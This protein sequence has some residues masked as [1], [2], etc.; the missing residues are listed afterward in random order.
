MSQPPSIRDY[1]AQVA[2]TLNQAGAQASRLSIPPGSPDR[3]RVAWALLRLAFD[4]AASISSLFYHHGEELAGSPFALLRPMNEALRRGAWI[5]L[6]ASDEAVQAFIDDDDLPPGKTMV[7]DLEHIEPFD[8][9][10]IFSQQFA[11]AWTKFH[12]FTHAGNQ[13][14]GAYTMGH[15]IG[16]S[17]PVE[18]IFK[19]LDHAEAIAMMVVQTMV[20]VAGHFDPAVAHEVLDELNRIDKARDRLGGS[21]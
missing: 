3:F 17:F 4:H 19:V 18:D 5:G 21:P 12:S 1:A 13:M 8:S 9:Y 14:V 6:C 20:M 16:P 11:N 10:P 15:G 2:A 7:A